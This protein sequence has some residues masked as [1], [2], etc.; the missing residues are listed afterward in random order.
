MRNPQR[1]TVQT[2]AAILLLA[3]GGVALASDNSGTI[4]FQGRVVE[5]ACSLDAGGASY[6]PIGQSASIDV[7]RCSFYQNGSSRATVVVSTETGQ[8]RV[9][10]VTAVPDSG[11]RNLSEYLVKVAAQGLTTKARGTQLASNSVNLEVIYK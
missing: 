11:G 1:K 6:A 10:P 2:L 4:Q 5:S 9:L 7:G 3:A 8:T